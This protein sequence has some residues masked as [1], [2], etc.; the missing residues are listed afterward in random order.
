MANTEGYENYVQIGFGGNQST[1]FNLKWGNP[2]W[3]R[4]T[5]TDGQTLLLVARKK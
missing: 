4:I 2:D 5:G 3:M 1:G